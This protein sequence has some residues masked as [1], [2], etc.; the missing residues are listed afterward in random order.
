MEL[1]AISGYGFKT[2]RKRYNGSVSF[3][4]GRAYCRNDIYVISL[5]C[6]V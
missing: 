4:I 2:I 5:F 6:E 3:A 1:D